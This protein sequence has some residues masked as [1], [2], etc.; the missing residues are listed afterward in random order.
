[1]EKEPYKV[2]GDQIDHL[3]EAAAVW[4]VEEIAVK[5]RDQNL[6]AAVGKRLRLYQE[7]GK[8]LALVHRD[9]IIDTLSIVND[10]NH[11]LEIGRGDRGLQTEPG[12]SHDGIGAA[13]TGVIAV[14]DQENPLSSKTGYFHPA[15]ELGSFPSEHGANDHVD[16]TRHVSARKKYQAK[17]QTSN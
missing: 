3:V 2:P 16:K 13:P 17:E 6:E 14:L 9:D 12:V 8:E 5:A 10:R 11:L 15:D 4:V 1:M 7:V